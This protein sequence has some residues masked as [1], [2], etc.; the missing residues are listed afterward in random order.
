MTREDCCLDGY[1][2]T[3]WRG[4]KDVITK[5]WGIELRCTANES[6]WGNGKCEKVAGLLKERNIAETQRGW[7]E[8]KGIWT[9]MG[10]LSK[11]LIGNVGQIFTQSKV[12][13][14][15]Q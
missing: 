1:G 8:E 10:D 14:K 15:T 2:R 4:R 3:P 7:I 9:T 6:L 11:K 5:K 13:Q 12:I